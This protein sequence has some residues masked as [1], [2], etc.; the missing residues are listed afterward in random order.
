MF[1]SHKIA[2]LILCA[3]SAG[4]GH[5]LALCPEADLD[6]DCTIDFDDV[7]ALAEQWLLP[8]GSPADLDG[9]NGV[10]QRDFALLAGAW[11][12]TGMPLAINEFMA[13]NSSSKADPQGEYDDWIEIYNAGSEPIDTAGMYLTDD[14]DE[15][16][17]WR[18]PAGRAELTTIGHGEYLLIWADNDINHP[19]LHAAFELDAD[20]EE[21]GLFD[22][23]ARTLID[24]VEF[25]DQGSDIS[26]GRYPDGG[27]TWR[28]FGYPSPGLINIGIYQGFVDDVRFSRE[29]G[30][31]AESFS[32][33]MATETEGVDI[34]YTT[35][36]S[37]PYEMSGRFPRGTV[38]TN[39]V[40][41]SSTTCLRAKAVKFG[42]KPSGVATRAY[43]F[44]GP[45]VRDFS[46]NLPLV[47]VD[48][49]GGS[50]HQTTQTPGFAGFVD[51]D[52]NGRAKL[53]AT[54]SFCGR[55]A[56]N[57]RGK[58]STGFPKKQYHLETWDEF[59][60]DMDVSI[61]GLPPESDW[62][63][64][65]P[66]SDKSLMRNALAYQWSNDIGRY[67][68]RTRF[69]EMFLNTGGGRISMSDYVG[70]YV[71]MEKIKRNADRVD[72][73]KL[74]PG[75]ISEPDISGGY[76]I[77]KDKLDPGE[78]TFTTSTGLVL[79]PVEPRPPEITHQQIN[80]IKG[81]LNEFESVLSGPKSAD[82]L[83]GYARYIDVNS[84]I[85]HHIIVEL[86]KNIDGFRLS[87]YMFKDRLGTLNMGPVWDYNLSLGNADYL[88]GWDPTGWYY[89]Q[90]GNHDYPWWRKLFEDPEFR[91]RYA[92]RWFGLRRVLFATARLLEKVD[93]TAE[94]L[95]EAQ[96]RNFVRWP[97]LGSYVWPNWFI[98]DSYQE[99]INW[100]KG[101]LESRLN[102]MDGRIAAEFAP[103]PPSLSHPGGRVDGSFN[104]AMYSPHGTIYYT[105]DGSDPRLHG[106]LVNTS[107]AI[108][109][110][111]AI[112]IF[113]T[114]QVKARVKSRGG[115]WSALNEA[116][117]SVGLVAESLRIS[118]MMYHPYDANDPNDPN[119][120][121]IEL[122]N[123]GAESI[124]LN[125]VRFTNGIDFVFPPVELGPGQYVLVVQDR[126]AFEARYGTGAAI[127]GQYAGRLN[128]GGERI[129]L[130]DAIGGTI[131]DF[132]YKDGWR[133]I[134]DGYGYSLTIIDAANPDP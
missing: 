112:N 134:A 80:W 65:G 118:E 60:N 86:A 84:F 51:T 101:W 125:L 61:L 81:Y 38:Y 32:V 82:P 126:D 97:V 102:W 71:L 75:D 47:V 106:G 27:R 12:H 33:A 44:L 115:E 127:A 36:G 67:A 92:D 57:I 6:G 83:Y 64:Q 96:A 85:D 28:F 14:L 98:A 46:S 48:T 43:I 50:V 129:R 77:K 130:E 109:Y 40:T 119:E 72:I 117:Y 21:I 20:G 90:L 131:L 63:L 78:M 91:L 26:F 29:G 30:F 124:N 34:W 70:V 123:I 52:G 3:I 15:P 23:D 17:K 37:E 18:I 31:Y 41:I 87:T 42:W 11:G 116:V 113:G 121:Y 8:P 128:N 9:L 24:S 74:G 25:G 19:G 53:T 7:R 111:S 105:L 79:I 110:R 54:A 88:R 10:E 133:R 16:T 39:P 56:I 107:S 69:V 132:K 5:A 100:M 49:F 104:L 45:D 55:A 68:P 103:A 35:D 122:T 22:R 2:F 62:V 99:E 58:S 89:S 59:D 108:V 94:L 13:S 1:K 73:A 120:E 66:Y 93:R 95:D 76:I 4:G 114:M